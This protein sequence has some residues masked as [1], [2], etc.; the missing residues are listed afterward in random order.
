[1]QDEKERRCNGGTTFR[2]T[3]AGFYDTFIPLNFPEN[4]IFVEV[5]VHNLHR[6]KSFVERDILNTEKR[7]KRLLHFGAQ[8]FCLL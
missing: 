4:R 1:L 2:A 7:N 8:Y 5:P 3:A 6:W